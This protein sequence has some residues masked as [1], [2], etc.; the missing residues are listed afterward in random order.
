M[1]NDLLF[2]VL[3]RE[4]KVAMTRDEFKVQQVSKEASLRQLSDEEKELKAEERESRQ[5]Q[6]KKKQ[7][8]HSEAEQQAETNTEQSQPQDDDDQGPPH[9]DI[10]V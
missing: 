8:K 2:S 9:L 10:F 3:P 5:Q 6:Q 1:S 4:G 7:K